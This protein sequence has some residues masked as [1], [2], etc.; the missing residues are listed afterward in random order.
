M[1]KYY[2]ILLMF[3]LAGCSLIKQYHQCKNNI[4]CKEAF[5]QYQDGTYA[6]RYCRGYKSQFL[7]CKK[8]STIY[9]QQCVEK[10]AKKLQLQDMY[11]TSG[12]CY[13]EFILHNDR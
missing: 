12:Q 7:V 9:D 11:G 2:A 13:K 10:L 6:S 1:K 8:N 5:S 4:Y 3:I